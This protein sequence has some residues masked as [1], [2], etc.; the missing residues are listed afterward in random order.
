MSKHLVKLDASL[1]PKP[2]NILLVVLVG[3]WKKLCFLNI[4]DLLSMSHMM[5]K[6]TIV[7]QYGV[8]DQTKTP[9]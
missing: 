9:L 3:E 7:S 4:L 1:G 5:P 8:G 2:Q 6:K